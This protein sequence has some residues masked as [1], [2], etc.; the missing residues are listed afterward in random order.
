MA[1]NY[2]KNTKSQVKFTVGIVF[3]SFHAINQG[4]NR[5]KH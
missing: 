1:L 2:I 5:R 3:L 4:E